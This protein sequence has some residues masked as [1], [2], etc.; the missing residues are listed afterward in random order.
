MKMLA[1]DFTHLLCNQNVSTLPSFRPRE[2]LAKKDKKTK[3]QIKTV[4]KTVGNLGK[5]W[6]KPGEKHGDFVL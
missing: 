1:V 6:G 5:N 4:K 2:K 3:T